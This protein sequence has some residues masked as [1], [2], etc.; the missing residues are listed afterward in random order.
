M[1]SRIRRRLTYTNIAMTLALV[2]AMTGGAYAASK[3]VI[4][5]TKQ[6]SPKVLTA[7]KGKAGSAGKNGAQ[8]PT[9][10]QGAG[11][12]QGATG[13]T[14]ATG[15][16]GTTGDKG[17]TGAT[18]KEGAQGKEGPQGIEGSPWTAGGVLPSGQTEKGAWGAAGVP[19]AIGLG[20]TEAIYAPISFT[21]PLTEAPTAHVLLVGENGAGG[22]CPTTSNVENPEAEPGNLCIFE[23]GGTNVKSVLSSDP[24]LGSLGQAGKTGSVVLA[25]AETLKE[26]VL[27]KGTWAVTAK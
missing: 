4:T 27:V 16:T 10:P 5:S 12:P 7:L 23:Q 25:T 19:V 8:G 13:A 3:Y 17:A 26:G 24:A 18:G 21:I 14:G 1:F 2:F 6:I 20:T 11:G 15:V 9:G 22:G